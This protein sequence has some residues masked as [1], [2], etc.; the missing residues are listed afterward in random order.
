V[1]KVT[2]NKRKTGFFLQVFIILIKIIFFMLIAFEFVAAL[3]IFAMPIF[4]LFLLFNFVLS[5]FITK[6]PF[7]A[8]KIVNFLFETVPRATWRTMDD[9]VAQIMDT[10]GGRETRYVK[11]HKEEEN[12]ALTL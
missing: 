11:A 4:L 10:H 9:I 3:V 7:I 6:C 8:W 5:Y 1:E 12:H 2:T